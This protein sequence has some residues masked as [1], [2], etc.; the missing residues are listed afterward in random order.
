MRKGLLVTEAKTT[1]VTAAYGFHS[2]TDVNHLLE[3]LA[4]LLVPPG[5]IDDNDVESLYPI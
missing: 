1:G 2:V 3:Q 4:F 5:S